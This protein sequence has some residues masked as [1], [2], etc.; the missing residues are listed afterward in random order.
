[1]VVLVLAVSVVAVASVSFKCALALPCQRISTYVLVAGTKLVLRFANAEADGWL[2]CL[3]PSCEITYSSL[4]TFL[5]WNIED[6]PV[7]G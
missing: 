3:G 6:A 5:Q 7:D 1:V 4:K 2:F